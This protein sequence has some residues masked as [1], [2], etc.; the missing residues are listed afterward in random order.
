MQELAKAYKAEMVEMEEKIAAFY[1]KR[2]KDVVKRLSGKI[3]K[4]K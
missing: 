3:N 4:T 1:S 2:E